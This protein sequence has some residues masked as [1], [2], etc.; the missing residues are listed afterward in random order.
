MTVA[1]LLDDQTASAI[2]D[3]MSAARTGRLADAVNIGE[4]ALQDGGDAA[5][6]NAMLGALQCQSG[7]LEP[8][9]RHLRA[10]QQLK[11]ADAVIASNLATALAQQGSYDAA[12]EVL[13]DEI[14]RTDP[15]MRLL[16]IRAFLAQHAEDFETAI[17]IYEGIVATAP[18]DW[19]TWNNLGNA[20]RLAGD[21]ERGLAAL[22]RALE[23]NGTSGP[24]RLNYATALLDVGR[25]DEAERHLR[26]MADDFPDDAKP[27]RELHALMKGMGHEE[28][29]LEAIEE[30]VRRNPSDIE[31]LMALAAHRLSMLQ[32]EAAEADYRRVIDLQS[33]HELAHLGLAAV[34]ELSNRVDDLTALVETMRQ[35]GLSENI[36]NFVG[37]MEHRRRGRFAEGLRTLERVPETLESTRR[38]HLLGQL[39][40]GAGNYD[41][42]FEAF[43][44]TN[45]LHG[46]DPTRPLERGAAY[47]DSLR[48]Q[49]ETA[50]PE[51]LEM[52]RDETQ[53]DGPPTPAFLVGFP[54]SGTTLL[55]TMLMGHPD[56]QILEEEPT[57]VE[58]AK[59]L[60]PF[61]KLPVASDEQIGVAR[62]EYFRVAARHASLEPGKLLVDKNPLSMNLL[63]IIHRLFPKARIIL[64]LRH[65]CDVVLSCYAAN[66]KLNDAMP[67]FLRL[68]TAAELYDLSFKYFEKTRELF[69]MPVHIIRYEN[70]V[71][72]PEVEL[73]PL[74]GFLGLA[75]DDQVVDHE[76]TAAK[77][78]RIKTASYAQVA[79]PLYQRSA[80]R[81]QNF[82]KQL[83]PVLPV[84]EPWVRKFGY[85]I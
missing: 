40:E 19:E 53:R 21:A 77:R 11:P 73:R 27:L 35:R 32:N 3:A 43:S 31:L 79:E 71:A 42:A 65:P 58:A 69:D 18:D 37:A 74:L 52:W 6:L 84:L 26:S 12:L 51:W 45:E 8:G 67:N 4:R 81:W 29:A 16:R 61:D 50:T 55:D 20:R 60:Q 25:I 23:L 28:A 17:P 9:I 30:A 41:Q 24:V 66:F 59:L 54:R 46:Q 78:G 14:A 82:R 47:R 76:A 39:H 7:H 75:W 48:L 1:S 36:L 2:R 83:E 64:A 10:A 13:T 34:F 80:G 62:D 56:A 15:T 70:V 44:R 57:L 72:D 85:E 5:A 22:E 68:D 38:Y 49:I 63:P 33:D